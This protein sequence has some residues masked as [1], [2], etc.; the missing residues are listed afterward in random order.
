MTRKR[1]I[2]NIII[3]MTSWATGEVRDGQYPYTV[4]FKDDDANMQA[5][6][7]DTIK[8]AG[9]VTLLSEVDK[10]YNA[11]PLD[12]TEVSILCPRELLHSEYQNGGLAKCLIRDLREN[13]PRAIPLHF[14]RDKILQS[15]LES[16]LDEAIHKSC[17]QYVCDPKFR[18]ETLF[19]NSIYHHTKEDNEYAMYVR[20]Y[21]IYGSDAPV[22]VIN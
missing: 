2:K 9:M 22:F 21:P 12:V 6:S 8:S 1:H 11:V 7:C 19:P 15:R 17:I 16:V 20:D 4:L 10:Q 3:D 5:F 14:K 18:N 13:G